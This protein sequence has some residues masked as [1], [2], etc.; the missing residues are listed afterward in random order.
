MF[1]DAVKRAGVPK[2][3]LHDTRHTMAAL[4]LEAGVHPEVVQEQLGHSAIAVTGRAIQRSSSLVELRRYG[5]DLLDGA[6]PSGPRSRNHSPTPRCL[7]RV[8]HG[9]PD[10]P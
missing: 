8:Q 10:V 5:G 1:E 7:H 4:A 3:R 6:A 2:I 9:Q